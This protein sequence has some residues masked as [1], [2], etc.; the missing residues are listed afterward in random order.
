MSKPPDNAHLPPEQLEPADDPAEPKPSGTVVAVRDGSAGV[1]VLLLQRAVRPGQDGAAPWVFPGGKVEPDDHARGDGDAEQSA[2]HAAVR[3]AHEEA[4]LVVE[5]SEL[6][7]ISRWITPAMRTKR[8]DTW[9]F[10]A[11]VE[12]NP[13]IE[14]DGQEIGDHAWLTPAEAIGRYRAR[15]LALAPPTFVTVTWLLDHPDTAAA[16]ATLSAAEIL[17]FRPQIHRI[18]G[19][20]C[21]LYPGDAGY[22]D[23]TLEHDGPRHRLWSDGGLF[24]Y[25]R[26]S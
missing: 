14:V 19:G 24:R 18:E 4:R 9:F 1:E 2:R 11:R 17:T 5:P 8:F 6:V 15:A 22:E 16:S 3:E 26:E 25:E 23:G 21:I 13:A 7:T 10:L 12:G 20:A